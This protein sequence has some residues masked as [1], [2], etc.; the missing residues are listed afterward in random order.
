MRRE[1]VLFLCT[2]NSAHS[3][4]AEGLLRDLAGERFEVFSARAVAMQVP[5]QA[6]RV[7]AEIRVDI[8]RQESKTLQRL[9]LPSS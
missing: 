5:P 7:M 6:V 9:R 2:H 8:R 4:M 3:Q 1:R